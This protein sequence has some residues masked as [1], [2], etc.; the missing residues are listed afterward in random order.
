MIAG[1]GRY[2]DMVEEL[3]GKPT[4][5][6]GFGS[7]VDRI[8]EA[9]T[10]QKVKFPDAPRIDVYMAGVGE[11]SISRILEIAHLLRRKDISTE[12]GLEGRSLKSQ[13][14]AANKLGARYVLMIGD[15]ELEKGV[16]TLKDMDD[17]QQETV[18]VQMIGST[19]EDK[20]D[21]SGKKLNRE[22]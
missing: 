2:N 16:V 9:M 18:D 10:A 15:D 7:G 3:G 13:M 14:K 6:L 1:G 17:G 20:L 21:L 12:T 8:I 19:I 11:K 22:R 5:A 4:P